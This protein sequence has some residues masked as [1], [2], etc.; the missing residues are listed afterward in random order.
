MRRPFSIGI[1]FIA[2]LATPLRGDSDGYFCH[3]GGYLAY[4]LSP[5]SKAPKHVLQLVRLDPSTA[6][7]PSSITTVE[8]PDFQL[9]GL[10]CLD[11]EIELLG[12]H[13][14]YRVLLVEGSPPWL[15]SEALAFPGFVPDAFAS[16]EAH[17]L[18]AWSVAARDHTVESLDLGAHFWLRISAEC[19]PPCTVHVRSELIQHDGAGNEASKLT[20]YDDQF[21]RDCH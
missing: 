11:G 6:L 18:G 12:W 3:S 21:E 1:L 19:A 9:H 17:N 20:L 16:L 10:R 2:F 4:N 13:Q 15:L 14:V 5:V 7:T 8:L